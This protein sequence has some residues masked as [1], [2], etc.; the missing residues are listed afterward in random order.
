MAI[1][2]TFDFRTGDTLSYAVGVHDLEMLLH[3]AGHGVEQKAGDETAGVKDETTGKPDVEAM[4]FAVENIL[5]R[6]GKAEA[7]FKDRWYAERAAGDGFSGAGTVIRAICETL[8]GADGKPFVGKDGKPRDLAWVK[9]FLE[10]KLTED[11]ASGGS[12]TRQKLYAAYRLPGTKTAPIIARL[13]QEKLA[14]QAS[15]TVDVNADLEE[16]ANG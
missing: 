10:A 8:T 15:T 12:L 16:M 2:I 6:M 7:P 5:M 3:L 11:K 1:D 13:E 4:Y 9:S 14:A